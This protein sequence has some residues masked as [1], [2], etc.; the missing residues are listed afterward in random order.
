MVFNGDD[1]DLSNVQFNSELRNPE[2][3]HG[4][5]KQEKLQEVT[6]A[7]DRARECRDMC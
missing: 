1:D 4:N 7:I 5:I 2:F 3:F 6:D